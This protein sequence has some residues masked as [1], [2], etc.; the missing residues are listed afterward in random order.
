MKLLRFLSGGVT[1]FVGLLFMTALFTMP[2]GPKTYHTIKV[3]EAMVCT[4]VI[5]L[6]IIG[7]VWN[8]R[9]ALEGK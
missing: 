8:L 9:S 6:I 7:G 2:E 5:L 4:L 3:P 1:V